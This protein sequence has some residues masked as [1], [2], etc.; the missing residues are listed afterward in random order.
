VSARLKK[1]LIIVGCGGLGIEVLSI[2]IET[3]QSFFSLDG[4][5]VN[6]EVIGFYDDGEPAM[7]KAERIFGG[8][9]RLFRNLDDIPADA[10]FIIAVGEP[11]QRQRLFRLFTVAGLQPVTLIHKSA[12]VNKTAAIGRGCILCPH[13]FVGPFAQIGQNSV[14]NNYSSVAHDARIG[15]SS[16]L[17]PYA[18]LSGFASCGAYSLLATRSTV[19]VSVCLGAYSKL[20]AGSILTTDTKDGSLAVGNPAKHRVMFRDPSTTNNFC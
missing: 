9:L 4:D 8:R 5:I 11:V 6:M 3:S 19:L 7:G 2:A 1:S 10:C 18:T 14:I 15:N 20:S 16:V 13:V 12:I 17:H